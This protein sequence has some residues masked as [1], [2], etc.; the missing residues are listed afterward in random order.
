MKIIKY[1]VLLAA[2]SGIAFFIARSL[3]NSPPPPPEPPPP[4]NQFTKRIKEEIDSIGRLSDSVLDN[5]FYKE[6]AWSIGNYHEQGR[7]GKTSLENSRWNDILS[8]ELYS[9][10]AAKFIRQAFLVFSGAVWAASDLDFVRNEFQA[11]QKSEWLEKDSPVDKNFT[12]IRDNFKKYDEIRRFISAAKRVPQLPDDLAPV[13]PV[14][15]VEERMAKEK[16][17]RQIR[18]DLDRGSAALCTR[19]QGEMTEIPE[20]LFKAH[21]AYLD[22]KIARWSGSY[23]NYNRENQSEYETLYTSVRKEIDGF[24]AVAYD[25]SGHRAEYRRLLQ[26]W[27]DDNGDAYKYFR[28][29]D[30]NY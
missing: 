21:I 2:L 5:K 9:V 8:K 1:I 26:K 6:V 23:K 24:N 18:F 20:I 22:K 10:Y 19:L 14:E 4:E 25:V 7:F 15:D 30:Y 11:L 13:F 29:L 3:V 16:A 12:K 27:D 17:Y 28:D